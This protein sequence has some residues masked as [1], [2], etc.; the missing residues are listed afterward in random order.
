M[1]LIPG[2]P[3]ADRPAGSRYGGRVPHVA[4]GP[5]IPGLVSV[6]IPVYNGVSTIG[7]ALESVFRQTYPRYEVIVIDDGSTDGTEAAV[8]PWRQRVTYVQQRNAGAAMARNRGLELARGEYIA[9]LDADDSWMPEKLARQVA[10]LESH[11]EIALVHTD[12]YSLRADG[13]QS[14]ST[15]RR[16]QPTDGPN[17]PVIFAYSHVAT[18]SAMLR[19]SALERVGGLDPTLT[20]DEDQDLWIRVAREGGIGLIEEPLSVYRLRPG[21]YSK[22]DRTQTFA[23]VLRVLEVAA[24]ED[25]EFARAHPTLVRKRLALAHHELALMLLRRDE[26]WQARWHW[27]RAIRLNGR[28]IACYPYWVVS[29]LPARIASGLRRVKRALLRR[30]PFER[31]TRWDS[32]RIR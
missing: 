10:Y 8:A 2:Q 1:G 3:M 4:T 26:R 30:D 31:A 32:I 18:S 23:A 24:A 14:A 11:P 22:A 19:R 28:L 12:I 5:G 6:V 9:F 27:K 13:T 16:L 29:L 15:R 21:S 7:A 17:L 20:P 25:P